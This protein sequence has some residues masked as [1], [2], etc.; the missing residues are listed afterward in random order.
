L[1]LREQHGERPQL[2]DY[3]RRFPEHAE[4]LRRQ[5]F[6]HRA[7]QDSALLDELPPLTAVSTFVQ[8]GTPP[9]S[10]ST[11]NDAGYPA[12]P[13]YEIAGELGRGGMGIVYRAR[14]LRPQRTVALKMILAGA[15]AEA[16]ELARFRAEA[17]AVARLQHP[18]V[19]QI[20]EVGEHEGL[21]FFSLEYC[22]GGNLAAKLDGTPLPP[23]GAAHLVETV[24]RAMHVAHQA[25]IVHRDLKP[26]N[27]L[28]AVDGTPRSPTSAWQRSSTRRDKRQ[29]GR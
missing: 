8:T 28:L 5:F 29:P 18:N 24:A 6:L 11:T 23:I 13:G 14:Q 26:A 20:Y 10:G 16:H 9:P 22:A 4:A 21:P 15:H 25:G 17:E 7:L 27:V 1:V 3:L 2:D 12:L 19:V